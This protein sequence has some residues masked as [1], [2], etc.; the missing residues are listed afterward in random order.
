MNIE[1]LTNNTQYIDEVLSFINEWNSDSDHIEIKTSG[2]TGKPKTIK[3][4]KK[5]MIASAEMTGEFLKLKKDNKALL[6]LS[7]NTV[8]GK[9]MIVRSIV[10]DLQLIVTDVVSSPLKKINDNIDFVAMV[11]LQVQNSLNYLRKVSKIIVGGGVISNQLWKDISELDIIAYQTFGMT[12]TIS[13]IAMREISNSHKNYMPLRGV[14]LKTINDCLQISAPNIGVE[15]LQ[16]NDI[17][18]LEND[19]PAWVLA[20]L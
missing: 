7:P 1:F 6:C 3:L 19:G 17:V 14:E 10:L 4:K 2:S 5:Y 15:G 8:A 9:M 18:K 16:T 12:E 20:I 11:P 13:H